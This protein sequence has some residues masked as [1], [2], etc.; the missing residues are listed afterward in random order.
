MRV[1]SPINTRGCNYIS[2][3]K[4]LC[5][6][7]QVFTRRLQRETRSKIW[8]GIIRLQRS[9]RAKIFLICAITYFI[10]F[11][12]RLIGKVSVCVDKCSYLWFETRMSYIRI[13]IAKCRLPKVQIT[14]ITCN[15]GN[16]FVFG[17]LMVQ[18]VNK[19]HQHSISP[20]S[21]VCVCVWGR[22]VCDSVITHD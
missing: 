8:F 14:H 16:S 9:L 11:V 7:L 22:Q 10:A 21:C 17:F 4:A 3:F 20:Y 2:D 6:N 13:K 5:R 18:A 19:L 12:F 15:T 1:R